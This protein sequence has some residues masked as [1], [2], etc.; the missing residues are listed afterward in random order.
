[1]T[2]NLGTNTGHAIHGEHMWAYNG[3]LGDER[4]TPTLKILVRKE[5]SKGQCDDLWL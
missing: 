4:N 2:E 3:A 5:V 1:L